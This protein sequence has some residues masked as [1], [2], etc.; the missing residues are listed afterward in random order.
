MVEFRSPICGYGDSGGAEG[1]QRDAADEER[2]AEV[3][4]RGR[5]APDV[6]IWGCAEGEGCRKRSGEGRLCGG[7]V[8]KVVIGHADKLDG[9]GCIFERV[10]LCSVSFINWQSLLGDIDP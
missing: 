1:G 7:G 10:P 4:C 8:V 6:D 9:S 3:V 2:G 5:F